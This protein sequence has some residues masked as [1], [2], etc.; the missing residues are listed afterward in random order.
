MIYKKAALKH[1]GKP[2]RKQ[3]QWPKPATA[4]KLGF[5]CRP[6]CIQNPIKHL[7]GVLTVFT[8]RSIFNVWQGSEYTAELMWNFPEQIFME[9]LGTTTFLFCYMNYFLHHTASVLKSLKFYY[10]NNEFN[11]FNNFNIPDL[12]ILFSFIVFIAF[13]LYSLILSLQGPAHLIKIHFYFSLKL[14]SIPLKN[15]MTHA[16]KFSIHLRILACL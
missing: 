16:F 11:I 1:F 8:K 7:R 12:S 2:P 15:I 9:H 3:Q 5:H 14:F 13:L 10:F 6:S 4:L